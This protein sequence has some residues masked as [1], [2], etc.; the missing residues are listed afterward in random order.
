MEIELTKFAGLAIIHNKFFYDDRGY[1]FESYNKALF[2]QYNLPYNF[3]Q[4]NQSYSKYGVI[5]GMHM[6]YNKPQTKFVRCH[7]GS[8]I[9]V[10]VDL[11]KNSP[12]YMEYYSIEL[13]NS[14]HKAIMVP[15]GFLHGFCVTGK[16]GAIVFYKVDNFY[17]PAGELGI[18]CFDKTLNLPWPKMDY[19]ISKKDEDAPSL[20]EIDLSKLKITM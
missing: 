4:D 9:D 12:T 13:T 7:Y 1:F 10:V 5:R 18:N 17:N 15:A 19:L 8:I 6:Q 11:R 20:S 2:E 3:V 16:K 14:N